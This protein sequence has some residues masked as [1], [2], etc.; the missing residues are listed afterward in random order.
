LVINSSI[1]YT[2]DIVTLALS[3]EY[4]NTVLESYIQTSHGESNRVLSDIE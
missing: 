1:T 4:F 2:L 3:Y